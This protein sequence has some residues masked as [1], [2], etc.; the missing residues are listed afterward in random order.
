[1]AVRSLLAPWPGKTGRSLTVLGP[2]AAA[3]YAA[4]V[5]SVALAVDLAL[6]AGV[7]GGRATSF[8]P[9]ELEPWREARARYRRAALERSGTA[10]AALRLDVADCYRSIGLDTVRAALEGVGAPPDGIGA[11]LR[12]L[13][14]V[15]AAG[16]PGLPVGPEP[17]AVLANAVLRHLDEAGE[18]LE[19]EHLRWYDD[20]LL[21]GATA[22]AVLRAEASVARA[23]ADLGLR[24]HPGKR[25]L[26]I[27]PSEV[28]RL[29][30]ADGA[31]SVGPR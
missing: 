12:F 21:L 14:R 3:E 7:H 18:G 6:G 17:S 22:A 8:D 24:M 4:A 10:R 5:G 20:V 23:A 19:A 2:T 25:R 27:G 26:A 29:I 11:T 30:L 9:L 16:I 31:R 28:R 13:G 1:M 15:R